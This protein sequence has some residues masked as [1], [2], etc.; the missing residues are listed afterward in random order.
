MSRG[1]RRDFLASR[2]ERSDVDSSDH[3]DQ[4]AR[5]GPHLRPM[6]GLKGQDAQDDLGP[7]IGPPGSRQIATAHRELLEASAISVEFALYHGAYSALQPGDL[8][9]ELAIHASALPGMVFRWIGPDGQAHFQL[10][11]DRPDGDGKYLQAADV[12]LLNVLPGQAPPKRVLIVKGTKQC[13]AARVYAVPNELVIGI[14]GCANGMKNG[15]L[16]PGLEDRVED[17]PVTVIF[18][19]GPATNPQVHSSAMALRDALLAAGATSCAFAVVPGVGSTGLD[20]HLGGRSPEKRAKTLARIVNRAQEQPPRPSVKPED[21]VLGRPTVDVGQDR[22]VVIS[23]TTSYMLDRFDGERLFNHGGVLA[24][25]VGHHVKPLDKNRF[26]GLLAEAIYFYKCTAQGEPKPAWPDDRVIGAVWVAAQAFTPLTRITRVPFVRPDGTVRLEAGYDTETQSLLILDPE[27]Q[28]IVVPMVPTPEDV[29]RAVVLLLDE[30]LGEMPLHEQA[31]R[32]NVLALILTPFLRD[33][34]A[35]A[36]LAVLDGLM[37]GVGKNLLADCL[38]IV[39][40][41]SNIDPLPLPG[42]D[43]ELRKMIT[44]N[45][46]TGSSMF[47]FDE[48]HV[49]KG[50]SLAR[51]LTAVT[52][53]DRILGYSRMG[54]YPNKVTW[55]ALGNQ[56]QVQGD[57]TRRVYRIALR[58]TEADPERRKDFSKPDLRLWSRDNRKELV[59]AIL[60]LIRGWFAAGQPEAPITMGFGSFEQWQRMVGGIVAHAGLADFLGNTLSWRSES[61]FDTTYWQDHLHDVEKQFHVGTRFK[62]KWVVKAMK[63]NL[64]EE[65]PPGLYAY[66]S[67]A[68]SRQ[69]GQAYYRVKDRWFG[70]IR[71]VRDGNPGSNGA[72]GSVSAWKIETKEP[73]H[74]SKG[75]E[76][77]EGSRIAPPGVP[78]T[79]PRPA[80][81]AQGRVSTSRAGRRPSSKVTSYPSDPS[82][83]SGPPLSVVWVEDSKKQMVELLQ[84]LGSRSLRNKV[85]LL[86][87]R[88]QEKKRT[89]RNREINRALSLSGIIRPNSQPWAAAQGKRSF[90]ELAGGR[91]SPT[92][93]RA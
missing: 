87:A 3:D 84:Q 18:D 80:Q 41:G 74:G 11:P 53:S 6:P 9:A 90:A 79:S 23:E 86:A 81:K 54:S 8:P 67:P 47:V 43:D 58:P 31:D 65:C 91:A 77:S 27:L 13:L 56:V 40:T 89:S 68:Y 64:I 30:W 5:P 52:Y 26:V 73:H 71:L 32:A 46:G 17:L 78:D 1:W 16:L 62:I 29:R 69:L 51:A 59:E 35:L 7:A 33:L 82:R 37:M 45:F 75:P 63:A 15:E 60:T 20:D 34:V 2:L 50:A 66:D 72:S 39:V 83:P 10:R 12:Q 61:D 85:P 25:L 76:G 19:A 88:R 14:P 24:E 42:N 28:G 48:A 38:A 92:S 44:S 70:N 55:M 4:A 49:L 57:L 93:S 21:A 22:L 36:P